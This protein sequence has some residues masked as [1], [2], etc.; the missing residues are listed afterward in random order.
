MPKPI[1][2]AAYTPA[3]VDEILPRLTGIRGTWL[4]P[5]AGQGMSLPRFVG[6]GHK[7]VGVELEQ[8]NVDAGGAETA[9]LIEQGDA[10]AL[11]FRK[12]SVAAIFTSPTYGNRFADA[13]N[14]QERCS[15]CRNAPGAPGRIGRKKCERCDGTGK[16][17]HTRRS[18]THDLRALT[19]NSAYTLGDTNTGKR[20]FFT[21]EY[22]AL[23]EAAWKE[24]WRVAK[25]GAPFLLNVSD[26]YKD[27]AIVH[28]ATWHL[29]AVQAV[30]F[31]WEDA[32]PIK[33]PRMRKG[34]NNDLRV[35]H[36]W[37]FQFRKPA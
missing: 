3:V 10:T 2:P 23:H 16:R 22:R 36:E 21:V 24:C 13:H 17:N 37:L 12:E 27:K 14:A 9:G 25:P 28:C 6:P 31:V 1:F 4:D 26:F 33:T 15:A 18:Y 35:G 7:V 30:G 34:A 5:F 11:R 32:V 20:G 29:V 8:P 19:G